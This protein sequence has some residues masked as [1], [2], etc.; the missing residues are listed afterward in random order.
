MSRVRATPL[1]VVAC[2]VAGW[3]IVACSFDRSGLST[4]PATDDGGEG[5][6]TGTGEGTG[7]GT[8]TGTGDVV[9]AAMIDAPSLPP[10][11]KVFD[12]PPAGPPDAAIGVVCGSKTCTNGKVCC[13]SFG[14]GGS[15]TFSCE[16]SCKSGQETWACDGPEDCPGKDCCVT[17]FGSRCASD[18]NGNEGVACR[19]G[20]DCPN[21]EPKCCP[22]QA[23]NLEVCRFACP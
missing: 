19:S 12:A 22:T 18:C 4:R 16:S 2:A 7:T 6:G 5:T 14:A 3:V 15:E 11:A 17:Q 9:D 21:D 1:L 13:I 10:D 8:G 20:D 23:P